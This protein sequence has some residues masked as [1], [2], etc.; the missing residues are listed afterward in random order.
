M[1]TEDGV[2]AGPTLNSLTIVLPMHLCAADIS[3][4]YNSMEAVPRVLCCS[5]ACMHVVMKTASCFICGLPYCY[6]ST[7]V[8]AHFAY[9]HV[10]LLLQDSP[11]A[12]TAGGVVFSVRFRIYD[13]LS[14]FVYLC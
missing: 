6:P 8:H 4:I 14:V 11:I 10:S 5:K 1:H 9:L 13:L 12:P 7:P 2:G 3:Q